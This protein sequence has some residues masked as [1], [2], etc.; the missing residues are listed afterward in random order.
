MKALLKA[1]ERELA[2]EVRFDKASRILYSTDASMYQIEPSGVVLPRHRQ[3]VLR[4]LRLAREFG[5]SVLPRGA[6]TALAGQSVG[7]GVIMDLSK[8][9][10]H[11][12]ELNEE[13]GWVRVQPGV[14][15]DELNSYLKPYGLQ[16]APD[17]ATSSRATIGGMI[18]NNSA[19]AHSVIY[20][21][22]IDHVLEL[23][24]ALADG[25]ETLLRE[26]SEVEVAGKAAQSD[27]EGE[28]YREVL[29]LARIHRSEIDRRY[30]KIL[31]RVGGYNLDEFTKQQP[32]NMCRMVVG[33][34]G[35]LAT[36]LEARLRVIP[37]PGA[38]VLGVVQFEDLIES[39]AAVAP[40]L[41]TGPAAV[42][43]VDRMILEQTRGSIALSRQRGWVEGDPR[44][45]LIVEYFG[46]SLDALMP[47]L[48]ALEDAMSK[49]GLGYG[50]RRA[51]S[52]GEQADVW[53]VRKSGLGLLM[54]VKGD[55]K[56]VAFVEDSAVSPEKLPD[57]IADFERI[58][59]DY[60]TTAGYYAH[61]SVGLLHIRPMVNLKTAAGVA[62][63]RGIAEAVRELVLKYGGAMSGEHGD[64]LAR[65]CW[66]ERVFGTTLYN[67]FREI[68]RAFDPRGLMNPGKIVDA[69][70]MTENLRF[71]P[72]YR[73]QEPHTHFDFTADGGFHR[74]VEMCN[75]V[76]A[77][78]KKL[79]GTMCP[80][81]MATLDEAHSTRG[82]ANALRA[83]I[84]GG[85]EGGL[86]DERVY[87][88]LDLCLEC[89]ACKSEC[90]S[91]VDMAKIKYEFLAHYYDA[92]GRPLREWLFGN[93]ET[94][95]RVGCALAPL[96][97]WF[98][99]TGLARAGMRFLG[100]AP[101]R[102]LPPFAGQTFTDWFTGREKRPRERKV[103]L[104]NDTYLTFNEPDIGISA[105]RFL[106]AAGY[107]VILPTKRCC[108]RPLLSSGLIE[109]VK[110][111]LAFNARHLHAYVAQGYDIVGFEPS[112]VSM[113]TDDYPE[114]NA[115]PRV[116]EV[117][118][119]CY[120][121]ESYLSLLARR[122]ELQVAFSD[123]K[124]EILVHG[125]CHQK[126]LW[127]VAPTLEVLNLPPGYAASAIDSACCGMAG[128]FGYQAEHYDVSLKM[129][130]DRLLKVIRQAGPDMEIAAAGLSCRQQIHHATG[131]TARHPIQLLWD[132][133]APEEEV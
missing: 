73:A 7:P 80:S 51:V 3:D 87:E 5:V 77:C 105:T 22:T 128:A 21:K 103:V 110:E 111:N 13:E 81:Y 56:P 74:A 88:I 20:G 48:D 67:A 36:V 99:G 10:N 66:N 82:R 106:E 126:A 23:E 39:M 115:D 58:V 100:I 104:F 12:L 47:R 27:L 6:G 76:G 25:T 117:S 1:L 130:E 92:H 49:H 108:G 71:G 118:E 109:Q 38:R 85:L 119:R 64:G 15:L 63:M 32:F 42:E 113:L 24:I 98:A 132:A 123:L 133:V 16:F 93:I 91:N 90:P 95:N 8:F 61:A 69:P 34:E 53:N 45:V 46:D 60:D 102:A 120:T 127:G 50:F 17:V 121:V 62:K 131:R 97:N 72:A 129:G 114:L 30:P 94:L 65:S 14:V 52:A 4:V 40:I 33:S 101:K 18:G 41:E 54:G 75:G 125:H 79:D 78:R 35:T 11:I 86:T 19:G 112:C 28:A 55:T 26:L 59:R 70:L 2:G 31:R 124:K 84:S 57:Y 68:K 89:K 122:G 83:A 44:A 9:M 29:R 37:L 116:R 107:E 96:S 43:L